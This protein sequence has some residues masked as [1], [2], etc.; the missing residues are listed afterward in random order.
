MIFS[1]LICNIPFL[2]WILFAKNTKLVYN[3]IKNKKRLFLC[4]GNLKVWNSKWFLSLDLIATSSHTHH[5]KTMRLQSCKRQ[6]TKSSF[7]LV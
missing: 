6:L 1:P 5:A 7:T 2:L 3:N 4:G